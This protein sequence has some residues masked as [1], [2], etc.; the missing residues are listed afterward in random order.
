MRAAVVLMMMLAAA[1]CGG[2]DPGLRLEIL[3]GTTGATKIELYLGTRPCQGC[4][5]KLAPAG[6][7]EKLAGQVWYLDGTAAAGTPNT[8]AALD[9]GRYVYDL[10]PEDPTRDGILAHVLVVGYD[11]QG[12]VVG[13]AKLSDVPVY[14]AAT[15]WYRVTLG[16]AT[17]APSSDE[18]SPKGD[19]VYVW[20]RANP[21]LAAC[22]GYEHATDAGIERLWFV[23]EDD[24]DCDQLP[25]AEC[26]AYAHMASGTV[27]V[28]DANCVTAQF[29]VPGT[30]RPSCLLGGPVC[31]DGAGAGDTCG[32][33]GPSYCLPDAICAR[34]GCAQ[35]L[36]LCLR[37]GQMTPVPRIKCDIP[38]NQAAAGAPCQQ[39]LQRHAEINLGPLLANAANPGT[40]LTTCKSV[41]FADL[42]LGEVNVTNKISA[43]Q[44]E[45]KPDP[46]VAPCAFGLLWAGGNA[47]SIIANTSTIRMMIV[48]LANQNRMLI[49]IE[50]QFRPTQCEMTDVMSCQVL[51]PPMDG[52]TQCARQP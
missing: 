36:G 40:T 51:V 43:G 17:G 1:S 7:K 12:K 20:R 8:T 10:R 2:A 27:E 44:V 41:L 45:L 18:L 39:T 9:G 32:P 38:F 37:D 42:V 52:I 48:E 11:A 4:D 5:G 14:H 49:P 6:V 16:A 15:E 46:L 24:T 34:V 13:I 33:V 19:R 3:A 30:P 29:A 50:V 25:G 28:K 21:D 47:T 35:N 23:P 26:D 22:V 31:I